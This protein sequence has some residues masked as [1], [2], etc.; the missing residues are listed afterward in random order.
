MFQ[1]LMGVRSHNNAASSFIHNHPQPSTRAALVLSAVGVPADIGR[2]MGA[3]VARQESY[4]A[5]QVTESDVRRVLDDIEGAGRH[6][7]ASRTWPTA[8]LAFDGR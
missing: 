6:A 3:L 2:P 1:T 4:R 7:M 8:V 5:L